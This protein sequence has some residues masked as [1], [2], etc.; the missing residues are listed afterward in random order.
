MASF[1]CRKLT[2]ISRNA[3]RPCLISQSGTFTAS[4]ARLVTPFDPEGTVA[5][6]Q[7][8]H[9]GGKIEDQGIVSALL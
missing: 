6:L 7:S 8:G 3:I 2:N 1:A 5:L 4:A 9:S